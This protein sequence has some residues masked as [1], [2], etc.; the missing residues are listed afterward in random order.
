MSKVL[1]GRE[2]LAQLLADN[3]TQKDFELR[4]TEGGEE[5]WVFVHPTLTLH[6]ILSGDV[7]FRLK[8]KTRVINGF[9]VPAPLTKAPDNGIYYLADSTSDSWSS[10]HPF[11]WN[12][13]PTDLKWLKRGLCFATREAA[14]ANAKAVCGI[15][16]EE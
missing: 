14:I 6:R 3:L 12:G 1:N 4:I 10:I 16:P 9:T 11:Y 13:D 15:N 5:D 7:M 2:F 8:P